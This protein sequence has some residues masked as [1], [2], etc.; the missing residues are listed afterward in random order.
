MW[1]RKRTS[2]FNKGKD[3]SWAL[4]PSWEQVIEEL[5]LNMPQS[6]NL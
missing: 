1:K 2:N 4:V 5:T 3:Y 6:I